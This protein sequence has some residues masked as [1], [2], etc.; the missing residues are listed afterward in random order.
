MCR[1][2]TLNALG[3]FSSSNFLVVDKAEANGEHISRSTRK[4]SEM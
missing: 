2:I 1:R 4:S 3:F